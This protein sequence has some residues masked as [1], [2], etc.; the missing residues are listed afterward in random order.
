MLGKWGTSG[1]LN[2]PKFSDVTGKMKLK[3]EYFMPPRGW[4]WHGDWFVDPEKR[5]AGLLEG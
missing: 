2:R 4:Q 3:Q 1:L 5:Y